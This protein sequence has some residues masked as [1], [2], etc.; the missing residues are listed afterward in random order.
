MAKKTLDRRQV[1]CQGCAWAVSGLA[2]GCVVGGVGGGPNGGGGV[3]GDDDDDDDWGTTDTGTFST[4]IDEACAVSAQASAGWSELP[5]GEFPELETVGGWVQTNVGGVTLNVAHIEDGCY[6]AME[7]SCTHEGARVDYRP[8]RQQFVC[9]LHG[10]VYVA[11]GEPIA[12]PTP[13]A[14]VTYPAGRS[15]DSIWVQTG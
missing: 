15:G 13:V 11:N 5:L 4:G 9:T 14:L 3:T 2:A 12:G 1:L 6:V 10:A 7:T 8:E